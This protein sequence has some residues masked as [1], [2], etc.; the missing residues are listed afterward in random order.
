MLE[1]FRVSNFKSLLNLEFRPAGI[2][3]LIGPNNSGKTSLCQALRFLSLTTKHDIETALMLAWVNPW[4]A[5]NVHVSSDVMEFEASARLSNDGQEYLFNYE[6][7]VQVGRSV[8]PGATKMR[9]DVVSEALRV[10]GEGFPDTLLLSNER[11]AV[12]LLHEQRYLG[13]S[14]ESGTPYVETSAPTQATM[15]NRL[16]DLETNRLANHFRNA[17]IC[18][19]HYDLEPAKMRNVEAGSS[20][21]MLASDGGNLSTVLSSLH[22]QRPRTMRRLT[23]MVR[24]VEPSLDV[25]SFAS[26]DNKSVFLFMEDTKENK[27]APPD[28]ST[29][30]LNFLGLTYII[31]SVASEFFDDGPYLPPVVSVEEPEN[32][33]FVGYFKRLF[34]EID[35]S[36]ENGQFIFTSHS[37]YFIDLFDSMPDGIHVMRAGETHSTLTKPDSKW[38]E[39]M[40]AKMPVGEMHFRGMLG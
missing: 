16:Y 36:G 9:F 14:N 7:K 27:F 32:G 37:P 19:V 4:N 1:F 29:G 11:G 12:R 31:L 35:P 21:Q 5:T 10:T 6:L 3:L 8:G 39:E 38:I 30:T 40:S 13:T 15:L 2:N 20:E 28:I 23:E 24:T 25:F 17:L 26:P 22:S 34:N 33:V 18:M